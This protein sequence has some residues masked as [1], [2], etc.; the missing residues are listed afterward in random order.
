MLCEPGLPYPDGTW[1][2]PEKET[3]SVTVRATRTRRYL[4]V[5]YR[6]ANVCKRFQERCGESKWDGGGG[7][8]KPIVADLHKAGGKNVLEESP[9]ELD[10]LQ[11]HEFWLS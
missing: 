4:F 6:G 3:G 9:N 7:M 1:R 5:L 11:G 10:W 8:K 2:E